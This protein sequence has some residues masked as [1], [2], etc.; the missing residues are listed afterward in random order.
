MSGIAGLTQEQSNDILWAFQQGRYEEAGNK[1]NHYQ[2]K[3]GEAHPV[4]RNSPAGINNTG[5]EFFNYQNMK[6]N[7]ANF[8]SANDGTDEQINEVKKHW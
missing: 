4:V 7:A 6:I 1:I 8:L 3:Y 2:S 5:S